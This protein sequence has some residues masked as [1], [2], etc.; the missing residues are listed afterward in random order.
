MNSTLP[1]QQLGKMIGTIAI[2][3]L[4]LTGVIWL[5]KSLIAP[6]KEQLTVEEYNKQ[7]QLEQ[8]QLNVYK[9]LPS[10]G[11]GNLL[12]DW[13]YLRFIQYFGDGDAR[14]QTGYPL[15]PD[16]FQLVVDNDPRFV[17]ANLKLAVSTSIFA[18]LPQT[19]VQLLEKSLEETPS[20]MTSP[21]Y[22]PYYLWIYKGVDELLFLGDVEAAKNS[23]TMAANWADT[24]P[25]DDQYNSKSVAQR[26]R[27]TV[28]FLEENPDSRKAQIAAWAQILTNAINEETVERALGEIQGLG[29]EIYATPDGNIRVRVPEWID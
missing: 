6:R 16:Y 22:P 21:V 25:E 17:D 26:R 28:K 7:Q 13:F 18:G 19:S 27:Q 4:S 1:R 20:Q 8:I 3:T 24:Y 9:G 15:S 23:N 5:Q 14:K 10:L 2:I 12:A 29:G 11:Y